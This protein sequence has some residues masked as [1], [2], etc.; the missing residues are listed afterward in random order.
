MG[1]NLRNK[2]GGG[3]NPGFTRRFAV[4]A[5]C[6]GTGTHFRVWA[7]KRDSVSIVLETGR[8]EALTRESSGYH[9]GFIDGALAGQRYRIRLDRKADTFP[10]PASRYQPEGP[11]GPSQIVDPS[12]F[13]WTDSEWRGITLKGQVIYELHIGTFTPGG[14]W[15]AAIERLP[16]LKSVGITC[17]E[18]MPVAEFTG[19]FGWGYDGVDLFAPAHIYGSPDDLKAFVDAA[20]A[21]GLGVILDVVYNHFGPDGCYLKEFDQDYFTSK[22]ANEWGEA[23][24]YDGEHAQGLRDFVTANAAY[25][26][27]EFHFDGLR[28]DA[29]QT[30][31]DSSWP[32][33]LA[34]ISQ[35][36]RKAAGKKHVILVAESEDQRAIVARPVSAGGYGMDAVWNDDFH[37]AAIVAMTGHNGAYY[38][39]FHGTPQELISAAKYGYLFQGQAFHW[40]KKR[41]GTASLDFAPAQFVLC[42]E[43]HDQVSNSSSGT[44][45]A[46]LAGPDS[47][48]AFTALCLLLPGT[49]MLFQ[50]QEFHSSR[51]FVFFADMPEPLRDAVARGRGEFLSQSPNIRDLDDLPGNPASF[52]KCKLDWREFETHEEAVALHRDLLT[53]RRTDPVFSAQRA[54]ALDGAVLAPS[55]FVLRFFGGAGDDRLL[56]V[57]YGPDL[58]SG[59]FAEPLIAPPDGAEWRLMWSSEEKK[60]GGFGVAPFEDDKGWHLTGHSALVL[61]AESVARPG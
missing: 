56:F 26:I 40:Q 12:Q 57:N 17:V 61:R 6:T 44:C 38:S 48:R 49:P 14:T 25:W 2:D 24:N 39:D 55:A 27:D 30:I 16:Q 23:L 19:K 4:G 1:A 60:Y 58:N 47:V 50:G 9:S 42:L 13:R 45:L 20:H 33:I 18:M 11:H 46:K 21:I 22:H 28:L 36:V 51:P 31:H 5:E 15:G 59:S 8:E 7:P 41:R 52:E 37:H 32:H 3:L 35:E 34:C 10:D 43:N 53:L 54:H 29:V